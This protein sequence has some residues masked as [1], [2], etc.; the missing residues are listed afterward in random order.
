M[1]DHRYQYLLSILAADKENTEDNIRPAHKEVISY[2]KTLAEVEE[3]TELKNAENAQVEKHLNLYGDTFKKVTKLFKEVFDFESKYKNIYV[4]RNFGKS[5]MF[6]PANNDGYLILG[7]ISYKPNIRNLIHELLHAQ[8]EEVNI[9]ITQNIKNVINN[10]PDEIYDNYKKPYTVVEES[11]VSALVIYL[12]Q[13]SDAFEQEEFSEQDKGLVLSE[14]YLKILNQDNR[15]ILSKK[16]LENI[17][18]QEKR[19]EP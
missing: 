7:N 13:K 11:L 10:L 2:I 1:P 9:R 8:L 19:V 12:T 14:F 18:I 5:G 3:L 6:I 15:E 16:Y 17:N 4:T